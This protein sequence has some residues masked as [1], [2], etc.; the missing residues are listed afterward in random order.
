MGIGI[1]GGVGV[2]FLNRQRRHFME[3]VGARKTRKKRLTGIGS[4]HSP[5][6]KMRTR[7]S[8]RVILVD[9]KQRIL[10][11]R[12][13]DLLISDLEANWLTG[14]FWVTPGGGLKAGETPQSA[15]RREVQEEAGFAKVDVGPVIGSG[16]QTLVWRG[17]ITAL[18]ETFVAV[19]LEG[20]SDQL[21]CDRWTDLEKSSITAMRWWSLAELAA[22]DEMILPRE[23]PNLAELAVKRS[24]PSRLLSIDLS[25]KCP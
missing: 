17:E 23:L 19:Y 1:E 2:L 6:D 24:L 10:L 16:Q 14:G 15:A 12:V 25:A 11:V 3:R 22:T 8:A 9:Q 4:Q 5:E 20:D 21:T 13:E 7:Q 18:T